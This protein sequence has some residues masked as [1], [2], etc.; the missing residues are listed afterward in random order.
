MENDVDCVETSRPGSPVVQ[1]ESEDGEG[2]VGLVASVGEDAL[3]PEIVGEELLQAA[4]RG[5]RHVCVPDDGFCVVKDELPT[6]AVG[7]TAQR[8]CHNTQPDR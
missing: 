6:I 3:S 7:V 5:I 4:P 8:Q 1:P 2:A